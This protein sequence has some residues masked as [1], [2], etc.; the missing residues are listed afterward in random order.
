[1]LVEN[2]V[3]SWFYN[4]ESIFLA[5]LE[6]FLGFIVVALAALD[7]SPLLAFGVSTGFTWTQAM[8]LGGIMAIKGFVSEL[9]RLRKTK[10]VDGR[11]VSTELVAYKKPPVSRK[12]KK[13]KND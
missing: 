10:E 9:A 2:K 11:L 13:K 4:S 3:S 1:M 7:W 8:I 5:R 6:V 12:R